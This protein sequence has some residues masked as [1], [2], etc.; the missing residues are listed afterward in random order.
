MVKVWTPE[1]SM[2]LYI[3]VPAQHDWVREGLRLLKQHATKSAV[4][5]REVNLD[6]PRI[7]MFITTHHTHQRSRR[8]KRAEFSSK[9]NYIIGVAF[10]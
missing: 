4:A 2:Y 1:S 10:S 8:N 6:K 7:E 3:G 9:S 5:T